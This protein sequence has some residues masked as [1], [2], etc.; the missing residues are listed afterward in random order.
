MATMKTMMMKEL[1]Y[2]NKMCTSPWM[3][4]LETLRKKNCMLH[5]VSFISIVYKQRFFQPVDFSKK[6]KQRTS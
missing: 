5:L 6:N 2:L 3:K 1:P 4:D